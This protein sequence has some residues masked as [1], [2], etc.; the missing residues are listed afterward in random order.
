M[1][2]TRFA[3]DG[4]ITPDEIAETLCTTGQELARTAGL[5]KDAV[6]RKDRIRS[7]KTEHRLREEA[8]IIVKLEPGFGSA[9]VAYAWYRSEPLSGFSGRTAMH[10]VQN[11]RAKEVLDYIDAVKA[12]IHA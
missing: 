10:L 11:G 5:D 2:L 7:D 12:G 3:D 8:N 1:T 4:L 6:G 9:L